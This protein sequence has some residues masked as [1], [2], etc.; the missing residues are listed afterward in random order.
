M[1]ADPTRWD[2]ELYERYKTYRD[3]PALDLLL[4]I[5]TTP[6]PRE[7]WDLGCGAGEIAAVLA[8]RHP[9]AKVHGLDSTPQMLAKA[10]ERRAGVDWTLGDIADFDPDPK[11]DLIFT[12]AALH[13][14]SDHEQLFPKLMGALAPGGTFACQ[15]PDDEGAAHRRVVEEIADRDSWRK[16]LAQVAGKREVGTP[17]DYHRWLAPLSDEIHIWRT[18][19]VHELAGDNPVTEGVSATY[20]RPYLAAL[21]EAEQTAF[22]RDLDAAFDEAFPRQPNGGVL[23]PFPRLFIVARRSSGPRPG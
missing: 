21:D 16:P 2:P 13:W 6:E 15:M 17:Q 5:P 12:N 22:L 4:Q 7:I 10:R 20:L 14:L 1:T 9:E 11:T 19:Y 8:A 18:T 23:F 3:R